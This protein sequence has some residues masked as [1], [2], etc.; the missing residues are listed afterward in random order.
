[1]PGPVFVSGDRID[2]RTYEE[3]DLSFVQ[4]NKNDPRIWRWMTSQRPPVDMSRMRTGFER[5]N[6]RSDSFTGL[7]CSGEEPVG[8]V[9]LFQRGM[10]GASGRAELGY[11]ITPDEWGNGYATEAVTL[12]VEHAFDRRRLHKLHAH[13]NGANDG[14]KRVLEKTGFELEGTFRRD[15]FVDGSYHD[16]YRFGLL[17]DEW[18]D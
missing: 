2:L 13:V 1:M 12:L 11:W 14:S 6:D 15:V 10:D 9:M 3:E 18:R 4:R 7:V 5:R 8:A 17:A 16:R